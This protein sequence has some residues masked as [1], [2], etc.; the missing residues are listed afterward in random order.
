MGKSLLLHADTR[1][2]QLGERSSGKSGSGG[3]SALHCDVREG[4][5]KKEVQGL[6]GIEYSAHSQTGRCKYGSMEEEEKKQG[7]MEKRK[8]KPT[9][10]P[11]IF[12]LLLDSPDVLALSRLGRPEARRSS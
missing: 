4:N 7:K 1:G 12:Q 9:K 5:Y 6:K 10:I 11:K 2:S 3:E 8:M